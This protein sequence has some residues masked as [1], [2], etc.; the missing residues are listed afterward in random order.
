[1]IADIQTGAEHAVLAMGQSCANAQNTLSIAQDAGAA[2]D[3]ISRSIT[4]INE[5]NFLIAT[6][7]EEQAQVARSVDSNLVSIRDLSIQTSAGA[8]Q[9][10]TASNELAKLAIVMS[11]LTKRFLT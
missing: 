11:D 8:N 3:A 6:A 10:A 7:S 1:M 4:E 9:T 2:L 5:R